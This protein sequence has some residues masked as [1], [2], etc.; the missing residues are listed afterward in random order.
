MG[1]VLITKGD[2]PVTG[3][4]SRKVEALFIYLICEPHEHPREV[5]SDM[6][7]SGLSQERAM[8]NLRTALSNL[9]MLLSDYVVVSRQ[10]VMARADAP[11]WLDV[12]ALTNTLDAAGYAGRVTAQPQARIEDVTRILDLYTG[13]F[14]AGLHLRDSNAF[15]AWVHAEAE[16]L[17]GRVLL[18]YEAIVNAA[19]AANHPDDAMTYTR[20]W[21]TIDPLA[22]AGH[23]ALMTLLDQTGQRAAALKQYE[24]CV[25]A[26]HDEL[27]VEP[28][29]ETTAL[30]RRIQSRP[31]PSVARSVASSTPLPSIP[32]VLPN[33]PT[34]FID[35]PLETQ[36]IVERLLDQ[37]CRLLTIVGAGGSGK[38]RLAVHIG[39]HVADQFPGGVYFV[40]L[41]GAQSGAFIPLEIANVL[42]L[43]LEGTEDPLRQ[44][45]TFLA[46]RKVLLILDNFEHLIDSANL[47]SDLLSSARNVKVLVTSR[48]WLNLQEEWLVPIDGMA[49]PDQSVADAL[50]YGAVQLFLA[51]ARRM[52]PRFSAEAERAAIVQ[53]CQLVEGMPLSIELAA[54]WLRVLPAAEIVKQINVK[55]L[56]TPGR[57]LPER[58]RSV[59]A[60]F[61]YSWRLLDP[62]EQQA[63][64]K[65]AV[66]R[67]PF[68]RDAAAQVAGVALP[69]LASLVEK[70][71]IRRIDDEYYAVHELLRQYAFERLSEAGLVTETCNAHLGYFVALTDNPDSRLHGQTQTA[72]LD[73]LEHEHENLR[74]ALTWALDSGNAEALTAGLEIGA[75]IW[76]FW[77]MRGHIGEGRTWLDRLLAAT[78]GVI[79]LA[80]GAAT[81]GAGYLT[82]IQ[83]DS[84]RAEALHREGLAIRQALNDKAGMGGSLS[85]L[86]VIA[87]GRGDFKAARE[88]Y[89]QALAARR[90][91]NYRIGMA[92]VLT[93]L[94]LLLQDQGDF[95]GALDY[96]EQALALFTELDDLQGKALILF[97][98]GAL[99]YD[100]GLWQSA[101]SIQEQAL[102]LHQ[103][104]GDRRMV[105][106]LL[107]HLAQTAL[108]LGERSV[109]AQYL[110]QSEALVLESGD[111]S[112]IALVQKIKARL[113]LANG[114]HEAALILIQDALA[115]FKAINADIYW[116]QAMI[117]LGDIQR[118]MGRLEAAKRAY[119]D[120]FAMLFVKQNQAPAVESLYRL[121]GVAR[122]LGDLE[123][124]ALWLGAADAWAGRLAIAHP[125][126]AIQ[127]DR[128]QLA[129]A[130]PTAAFEQLQSQGA[131]LDRAALLAQ[132]A[133][134]D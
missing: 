33:Q 89:E 43:T 62:E 64:M 30:Y 113:A 54:T 114:Y 104:L 32:V 39:G 25:K 79:T 82:W 65:I 108:S 35:R 93:N 112:N 14:L 86:G 13:D 2:Q 59:Q 60:V 11:I 94:S 80:R 57:N 90:E 55:F 8:G 87:W 122:L 12:R 105:G 45:V 41:A 46:D 50:Q 130:L 5:L 3:F 9:Q 134:A 126:P 74:A 85:N 61:D 107:Q 92:S 53:I 96:A 23:R 119:K 26:L 124:A 18:A 116:G 17:R 125:D 28:E 22:E 37:T 120:A 98:I 76:E 106:A 44:I 109:A 29:P 78:K 51:C 67:G 48:A 34:P 115:T 69:I 16:R 1:R 52:Q 24:I 133:A 123:Q 129:A 111:K 15:D 42:H 132:V 81:Q 100:R 84:E 73:R 121:S 101:R 66:F 103:E 19:M 88:F 47:I 97:N 99:N 102:Q 38:T 91:A 21:L 128:A 83:G 127:A 58:H 31:A 49:Y 68:S 56:S 63:L 72:W 7:W 27:G 70:S 4:I 118:E 75:S 6:F 131:A 110:E 10:S 40:A 77:L 95:S 71:L 36:Q 20:R 117:V